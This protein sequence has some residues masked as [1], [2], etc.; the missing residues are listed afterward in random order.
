M[1]ASKEPR[2]KKITNQLISIMLD[3]TNQIRK[4]AHS[5]N[6][7]INEDSMIF[8]FQRNVVKLCL[9]CIPSEK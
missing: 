1:A 5:L 9:G 6:L 8:T 7:T 4:L 3:L 2:S